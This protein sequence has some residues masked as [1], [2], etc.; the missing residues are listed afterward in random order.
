[1]LNSIHNTQ[2]L[3]KITHIHMCRAN[4][5]V[6]NFLPTNSRTG[7]KVNQYKFWNQENLIYHFFPPMPAMS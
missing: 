7:F 1:M 3:R 4:V 2:D 6:I 5:S